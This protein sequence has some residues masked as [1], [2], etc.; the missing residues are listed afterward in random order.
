M[1]MAQHP[2]APVVGSGDGAACASCLPI[3]SGEQLVRRSFKAPGVHLES[4][5]S[6]LE[7]RADHVL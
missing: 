5:I 4:A 1:R 6:R 7:S 2:T 3:R